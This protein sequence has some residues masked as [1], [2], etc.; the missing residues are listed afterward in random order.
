VEI[1]AVAW[2]TTSSPFFNSKVFMLN[3]I[4]E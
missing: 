3:F 4:V 1:A 2:F